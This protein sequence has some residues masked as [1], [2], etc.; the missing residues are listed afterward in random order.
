MFTV[1]RSVSAE[2]LWVQVAVSP[3]D[4][5]GTNLVKAAQ[6]Q[7]GVYQGLTTQVLST[8]YCVRKESLQVIY[9]WSETRWLH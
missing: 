3:G 9:L 4:G 1:G 8:S 7:R 2:M 6:G 5:L